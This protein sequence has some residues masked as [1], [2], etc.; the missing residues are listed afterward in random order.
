[1]ISPSRERVDPGLSR[2][3]IEPMLGRTMTLEA[4]YAAPLRRDRDGV[5]RVTGSRVTLDSIIDEFNRGATPEQIQEDFP[6]L[7]LREI[8]GVIAFYLDNRDTV[9]QYLQQQQQL[10]DQ[11]RL[12]LEQQPGLDEL[13]A[14]L[15]A[16]RE[17]ASK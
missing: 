15:R 8:Y 1:M 16:R 13:R 17:Q 5:I 3:L 14:R 2:W 7:S 9:Q 6:P 4:T 10:G 11:T 12:Q